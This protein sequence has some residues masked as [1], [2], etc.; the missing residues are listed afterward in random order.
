MFGGFVHSLDEAQQEY[1]GVAEAGLHWSETEF[2]LW[3]ATDPATL[4]VY[5]INAREY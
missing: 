3:E 4:A 2:D 5:E 1:Q